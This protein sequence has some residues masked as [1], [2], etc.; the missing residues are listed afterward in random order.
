M[1]YGIYEQ[2]I[3]HLMQTLIHGLDSDRNIIETSPMDEAESPGLLSLYLEQVVTVALKRQGGDNV[4][5]RRIQIVNA[6][7]KKLA[8]ETADPEILTAQVHEDARVLLALLEKRNA[9]HA[10]STNPGS[11]TVRPVTSLSQSSLFTGARHEPNMVGELKREIVSADRV[12]LLVSFIKWSG[13]RLM[14]DEL[15]QL[16]E[17]GRTLRVITTSYMGATDIKAIDELMTLPNTTIRVSYD[18]QRTRLHAKAYV[19][20]RDTGY[21]TAYIGSSNISAAA[22]LDGLEWNVKVSRQDLPETFEKIAGTFDGYWNDGDFFHYGVDERP[23]LLRAL[24]A[25]R[26]AGDSAALWVPFDIAP[27]GFQRQ[28]LEKLEAER[29]VLGHFRNLVVA[30][31]GTGKT[32]VAAFDYKRFASRSQARPRLLFVAHRE[33]I[34]RQSLATFRVV[35]KDQNFGDLF[36]GGQEPSQIGHLFVSI[37]TFNSRDLPRHTGP[38]Y[39]DFIVVDEFHHAA[40]PSYQRLLSYYQ[41]QVLLGLTA[42]P[43]RLDGQDITAYFDHHIAAEI[44]LPEAIDRCLLAPFHYFGVSDMVDLRTLRWQRGGYDKDQ[45]DRVYTGNRRRAELII[46]SLRKY[47]TDINQV[48]G[49]GFCVSVAHAQ[50]MAQVLNEAGIASLALTADSPDD[51]RQNA[52]RNLTLGHLKFIFVV[53]LYNEGVDIPEVNTILFLR[54]TES[55]T[56]FLQQLGRGLRLTDSKECLTVLDF[57]GRSHARY[58]F[59]EK[60]RALSATTQKSVRHEIE[61]GFLNV[62]RGSFIQLEKQAQSYI[63]EN[64]RHSLETSSGLLN[65]IQSFSEDTGLEATLTN[66]CNYYHLTAREFYRSNVPSFARLCVR[67]GLGQEWAEPDE[68]SIT[69]ALKKISAIDSRRWIAYLLACL[70][71]EAAAAPHTALEHRMLRMFHYTVWPVTLPGRVFSNLTDSIAQI[72]KNSRLTAEIKEILTFNLEH[73]DFVDEPIHLGFEQPLDLHCSYSRDQVLAGLDFFT[74]DAKPAMREGVVF[75][76]NKNLDVLFVTL[77]KS[78]KDYSPTTMYQDHAISETLFHW[79]SQ[80]TTSAHSRT[81][82]RYIHHRETGN[83]ILLFVRQYKTGASGTL[84]YVLLGTV[85]YMAHEGSRPMSITWRLDRPMPAALFKDANTMI[86]S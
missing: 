84:P 67:A 59:E 43:E 76:A 35:L 20:H 56:V 65:R 51:D 13:L 46:Q 6:L 3:D 15:R 78:E 69:Q 14:W 36:V 2:V 53:D 41:P 70:N 75:L 33:E 16:T 31:T 18:T 5:G 57:I 37:Q 24:K 25:E 4:L 62:P 40:A 7:V 30:A 74:D 32:V 44:R 68:K 29:E 63:L 86:V 85:Q 28:I 21:S 82:Q 64:I 81:G 55:L 79:Q 66:F 22:L 26:R 47:V 1:H 48:I 12:D 72:R 34:L 17:S 61:Q 83:R 58:R 60:F 80:S 73:L 9:A 39:Y 23:R 54:P 38:D 27:Y 52:K 49:L 10:F 71:G 42:T 50:F 19:F 45:L 8:E 77:N 11:R